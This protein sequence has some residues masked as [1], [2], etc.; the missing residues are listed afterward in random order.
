[1]ERF[2]DLRKT[3]W[4]AWYAGWVLALVAVVG[5][6]QWRFDMAAPIR[7]QVLGAQA[8][9]PDVTP[10]VV[11][12]AFPANNG[13]YGPNSWPG[14]VSGTASDASGV[15][16]IEVR[17][18]VGSWV[19]A[20]GTTSW[21]LTLA[22]PPAEGPYTLSVRATDKAP[23]PNT[24]SPASVSFSIDETR[25]VPPV[26]TGGPENPTIDTS[27]RF[28]FQ[29]EEAVRFE[30]QLDGGTFEACASPFTYKKVAVG[31]RSFRVVAIDPAGNRSPA[32]DPWVWTVLINKAFGISGDAADPLYPQ[33]TSPETPGT[34][35]NLKISN[36]YN[37]P[38]EVV[39][40]DA[41]AA[42]AGDCDIANLEVRSLA[43][44]HTT[45][46]VVPANASRLLSEL[47]GGS[48]WRERWPA[49]WPTIAMKDTAGN[50]DVCKNKT[51]KLSYRGTATKP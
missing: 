32:S 48:D 29:G 4:K 28:T 42:S 33:N 31:D 9:K 39:S 37:F 22:T 50:Q 12:A 20:T 36:P 40:I 21:S 30:C 43:A 8:K 44:N 7:T 19:Q 26:I 27:A 18:G 17:L 24:S 6:A 2:W 45:P 10:P 16:R 15:S 3:H 51:F 5:V 14:K 11:S 25:P 46:I 41:S 1:M 34:P 35:L 49:D 23:S 38:I 13:V 47:L